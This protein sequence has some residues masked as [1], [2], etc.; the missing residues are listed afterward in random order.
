MM[1]PNFSTQSETEHRTKGGE[2]HN[3]RYFQIIKNTEDITISG[4]GNG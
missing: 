3:N 1:L 2:S 4:E